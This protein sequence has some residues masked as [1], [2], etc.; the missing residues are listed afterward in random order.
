M[1]AGAT[2][3]VALRL[4]RACWNSPALHVRVSVVLHGVLHG[5]LE[6]LKLLWRSD[7]PS[8]QVLFVKKSLACRP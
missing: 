2:A 7:T 4:C 3:G 6:V 1:Y 8:L 5:F